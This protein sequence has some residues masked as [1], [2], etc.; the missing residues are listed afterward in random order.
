MSVVASAWCQLLSLKKMGPCLHSSSWLTKKRRVLFLV[1]LFSF[2]KESRLSLGIRLICCPYHKQLDWGL[3][4]VPK[5]TWEDPEEGDFIQAKTSEVYH[6]PNVLVENTQNSHRFFRCQVV[7]VSSNSSQVLVLPS[8]PCNRETRNY[9]QMA[10]GHWFVYFSCL[11][12]EWIASSQPPA[13][14]YGG[15]SP[16]L[17]PLPHT[18]GMLCPPEFKIRILCH[19]FIS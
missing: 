10:G 17:P 5:A 15:L 1:C 16:C 11:P 3:K 13:W 2:G 8:P 18:P 9:H 6:P 7:R 12:E 19:Y 4:S 14:H